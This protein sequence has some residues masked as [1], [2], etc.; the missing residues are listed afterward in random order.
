[1]LNYFIFGHI[2]Y[3]LLNIIKLINLYYKTSYVNLKFD[4]LLSNSLL[5]QNLSN[6]VRLT[7]IKYTNQIITTYLFLTSI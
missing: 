3:N 1:M 6:L 2:L 5:F 4:L 7:K